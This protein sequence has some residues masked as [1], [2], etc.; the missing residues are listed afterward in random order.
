MSN[1]RY[2][3]NTTI[4]IA[5]NGKGSGTL[6]GPPIGF[7]LTVTGGTVRSTGAGNPTLT[8]YSTVESA[9]LVI[10]ALQV[11]AINNISGDGLTVLYPGEFPLIVVEGGNRG[12]QVSVTLTGYLERF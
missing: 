11:A 6:A 7:S 8:I 9:G 10:A 3:S 1:D 4:S 5:Q 12:G 2:T